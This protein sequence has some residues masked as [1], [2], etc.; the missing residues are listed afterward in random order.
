[1]INEP[2]MFERGA[3]RVTGETD[4]VTFR[5]ITYAEP[6]PFIAKLTRAETHDLRDMLTAWLEEVA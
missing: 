1:V 4:G 6:F 2:Q 5:R 3:L